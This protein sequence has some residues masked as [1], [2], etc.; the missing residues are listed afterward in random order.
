MKPQN[1]SA[2][3]LLVARRLDRDVFVVSDD[4]VFG[5]VVFAAGKSEYFGADFVVPLK[6][7]CLALSEV[8][9]VLFVFDFM[10]SL[11]HFYSVSFIYD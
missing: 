5:S 9:L 8:H 3:Y 10:F 11:F 1:V 4:V 6:P 2:I 7:V